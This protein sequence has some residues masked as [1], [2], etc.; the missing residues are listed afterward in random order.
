M[1]KASKQETD[2]SLGMAESHCGKV[3][4]DD[5]GYC[6]HFI[7]PKTGYTSHGTC[8]KV[9]GQINPVFWCKLYAKAEK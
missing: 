3:F 8:K 1:A 5:K 6:K 7:H 4:S 9:E 2:Y